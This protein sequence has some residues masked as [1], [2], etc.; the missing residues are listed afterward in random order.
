MISLEIEE[1]SNFSIGGG[2]ISNPQL[3]VERIDQRG[4]FKHSTEAGSGYT[5]SDLLGLVRYLG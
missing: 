5:P 1:P 3:L 4:H 2:S